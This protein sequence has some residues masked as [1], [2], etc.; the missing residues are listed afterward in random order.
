MARPAK[1]SNLKRDRDQKPGARI[2]TRAATA[3]DPVLRRYVPGD[4]DEQDQELSRLGVLDWRGELAPAEPPPLDAIQNRVICADAASA[5]S[6]IPDESVHLV[7]TSPPY[8]NVIDYGFDGQ[9]GF[10]SYEDYLDQLLAVWRQCERALI[11]NGKLAIDAPIMPIS[12][13]VMPDQHTR[14]LKNISNDIEASILNDPATTLERFS[15]YVWQ[16]QT[17]EKMFGSYPHPPNLY[18]QNTIEFINVF[19]KP[20]KPRQLPKPVK[21]Q[22][23]LT[24]KQWMDLTRQVW[25]LYPEDVKRTNHPAP[26]PESLPNRVIAMYTFAACE[27]GGHD[28]PGDLVLDPFNG[29]GATCVAAKKLGRRFLGSDLAPH[30]C[31]LAQTRIDAAE[32]DMKIASAKIKH[33]TERKNQ[34]ALREIETDR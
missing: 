21:D 27:Q 9:L 28:F 17:T 30:F 14:H 31:R 3:D 22:S 32:V 7:V 4:G 29:A 5:L 12:K 23:K 24:D 15:L 19:V 26:F 8:W 13:K 18:E 25:E 34:S 33:T 16:K 2:E 20:G 11:P 1:R 10:C 6:K